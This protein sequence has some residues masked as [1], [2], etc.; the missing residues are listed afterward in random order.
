ML[1]MAL[2]ACFI[3]PRCFA[4]EATAPKSDNSLNQ[5]DQVKTIFSFKDEIGF[6]DDQELKL[7]ALLY[8]EQTLIDTDT[9]TLKTLGTELSKMIDKKEDMKLIRSKLEEI[10]KIQVDISCRNIEDSRKVEGILTPDQITKWKDI[11]KRFSSQ[12]KI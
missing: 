11:Q 10:S 6:S 7:K 3:A 4:Q 1:G 2:T 8:D 5:Q 9:N 12:A